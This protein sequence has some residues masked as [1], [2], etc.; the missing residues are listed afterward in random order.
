VIDQEL[1]PRV[2]NHGCTDSLVCDTAGC[3]AATRAHARGQIMQVTSAQA[4]VRA[5]DEADV[6]FVVAGGLAVIAHGY[7]RFTK[8]IDLV[9]Q[10]TADNV[11]AAFTA[12]EGIG[13]RPSVPVTAAQ[14]SDSLV[15]AT[16][17]RDKEMQVLQFW[18]DQHRATPV[19]IF[20]TEPFDFDVEYE[21]ALIK[22][23]A[24]AGPVRF[25]SIPTLIRMKQ[26]ADREQDRV[27]IEHLQLLSEDE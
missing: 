23:L 10:L 11:R 8:D 22:D 6:R 7:L 5:L 24:G 15:R 26:H 19:D 16:L 12:L 27:D 4:I 21:A 9:V 2:V 20:V 14:M 17:I 3:A 18:S 1:A 25:V 13:Y